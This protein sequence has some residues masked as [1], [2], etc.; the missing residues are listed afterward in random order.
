MFTIRQCL[1]LTWMQ[2]LCLQKTMLIFRFGSNNNFLNYGTFLMGDTY[3]LVGI[4]NILI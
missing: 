2:G 4:F 3:Y 1:P